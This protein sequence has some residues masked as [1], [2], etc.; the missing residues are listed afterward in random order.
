M[1]YFKDV[2]TEEEIR[3]RFRELLLKYDYRNPNKQELIEAIW[4][5]YEKKLL[6]IKCAAKRHTGTKTYT[7][8]EYAQ[9]ILEQKKLINKVL[10][11]IVV[12]DRLRYIVLR[13]QLNFDN[14]IDLY[15]RFNIVAFVEEDKEICE[16]YYALRRDVEYATGYLAKD[17][18][19]YD[20]LMLQIETMM[21][22]H[23]HQTLHD[24]EKKY[25]DPIE[26]QQIDT[27]CAISQNVPAEEKEPAINMYANMAKV[28]I[29]FFLIMAIG[30]KEVM[31]AVF[32]A[33]F[34]VWIGFIKLWNI[35]VVEEADK[36]ERRVNGYTKK[37]T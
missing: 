22:K 18:A 23:V 13:Q 7:R 31:I 5:E 30:Y 35:F 11:R 25:I 24:Y 19:E 34:A 28:I 37:K 36:K 6:H 26:M 29:L 10:R 3:E 8:E 9:F 17:E 14:Y 1:A 12:R 15:S 33:P 4:R 20:K 21:G 16:Q 2:Y 27:I 32:A